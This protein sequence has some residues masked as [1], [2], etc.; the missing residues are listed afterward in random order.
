[1]NDVDP[2]AAPSTGRAATGAVV[3]TANG[4]ATDSTKK[5]STTSVVDGKEGG[6][7]IVPAIPPL[8]TTMGTMS[9]STPDAASAIAAAVAAALS[10]LPAASATTIN[11][12][13]VAAAASTTTTTAKKKRKSRGKTKSNDDDNNAGGEDASGTKKGPNF[14]KAEIDCFLDLAEKAPELPLSITEWDLIAE[15][16]RTFFPLTMRNGDSL[17]RKFNQLAGRKIPTGD[18]RIP[19]EVKK[20]K[21]LKWMLGES[22]LKWMLGES[23]GLM[24]GSPDK[25]EDLTNIHSNGG[26]FDEDDD[27]ELIDFSG[28]GPFDDDVDDNDDESNDGD[29]DGDEDDATKC[30][31]RKKLKESALKKCSKKN[32]KQ[33]TPPAAVSTGFTSSVFNHKQNCKKTTKPKNDEEE[34]DYMKS[35]MQMFMMQCENDREERRMQAERDREEQLRQAERDREDRRMQKQSQDMMMMM[36]MR[37][38]G[39]SIPQ[40]A[41]SS[42]VG[43]MLTHGEDDDSNN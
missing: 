15:Q 26:A 42:T 2:I 34:T 37:T 22:E 1:M 23:A 3:G 6:G 14:T 11:P 29:D 4:H 12:P 25:G 13:L 33:V 21:E 5:P 16:H 19:P 27:V 24:T 18:P 39:M 38:M 7:V 31:D 28:G 10:V 17:R 35:F 32:A 20:A 30:R 40:Q 36:M 8:P 43:G 41:P 9:S